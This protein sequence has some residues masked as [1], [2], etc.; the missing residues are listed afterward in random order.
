MHLLQ[1]YLL[2]TLNFDDSPFL[3]QQTWERVIYLKRKLCIV[4]NECSF[5][6]GKIPV[7]RAYEIKRVSA[8]L[9]GSPCTIMSYSVKSCLRISNFHNKL[10]ICIPHKLS[11][12]NTSVKYISH[13]VVQ[14][15]SQVDPFLVLVLLEIYIQLRAKVYIRLL[16]KP[17]ENEVTLI[18]QNLPLKCC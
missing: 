18:R 13:T 3:S 16:N 14:S 12:F 2:W 15:L 7:M 6:I 5:D 17:Y 9:Y 10:I 11:I 4:A 8:N 1:T